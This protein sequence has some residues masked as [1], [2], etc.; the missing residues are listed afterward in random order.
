MKPQ[1]VHNCDA[2]VLIGR[3]D[4]RITIHPNMMPTDNCM[5]EMD[6]A[7]ARGRRQVDYYLCEKDDKVVV[8]YG[9]RPHNFVRQGDVLIDTE[10]VKIG[11]ILAESY[12]A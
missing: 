2:C 6:E 8:R 12:R 5:I 3:S 11:R 9:S 7:M 4:R 10:D 1:F